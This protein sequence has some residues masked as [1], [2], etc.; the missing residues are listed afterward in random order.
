MKTLGFSLF[1][2]LSTISIMVVSCHPNKDR[3][4]LD[5]AE[6]FIDDYPDSALVLLSSISPTNLHKEKDYARYS[7]LYAEALDKNYIDTTDISILS[8]AIS[9]YERRDSQKELAL[10]FYYLGRIQQNGRD[11]NASMLS[12]TRAEKILEDAPNP[13]LTYLLKMA[14]ADN[15]AYS[16]NTVEELRYT[17][18]ALQVMKEKHLEKYRSISLYRYASSLANNKKYKEALNILDSLSSGNDCSERI[19]KR[20]FVRSC[21]FK[22]LI[23]SES[24]EI[25]KDKF[26]MASSGGYPMDAEDYCAYAYLLGLN[27][28][29]RAANNLFQQI[30]ESTTVR[31]KNLR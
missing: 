28:D 21:Y 20:S 22:T 17:K 26:H 9:Y 1:F 13:P 8:P 3:L 2:T 7:L 29:T 4:I 19:Q 15:Y 24:P 30:K 31:R 10:S 25:L 18:D 16:Y 11:Y 5:K 23:E 12:F 27:G 6:Q 14:M